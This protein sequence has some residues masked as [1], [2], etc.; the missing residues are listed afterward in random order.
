MR[1]FLYYAVHSFINQIKKLFKTWVIAFILICALM[2][3]IIGFSAA[4]ISEKAESTREEITLE[5]EEPFEAEIEISGDGIL[6]QMSVSKFQL[7]EMIAGA[8][9]LLILFLEAIGADKNGS[10]IFLPADVTLLFSA[11]LKPQSVLLFRLMSQLGTMLL[12]SIYLIFQLPNLILN[13]HLSALGACGI[14]LTWFLAL[15]AAEIIRVFL[16]ISA[17]I[18][19]IVKEHLRHVLYGLLLIIVLG[20]GLWV[21]FSG[22]GILEGIAKA[23]T[24]P[25]TNWVPFWGWLKGFMMAGI[26]G[27]IGLMLV[28]L[29]LLVV[30]VGVLIYITWRLKADFYE[31]AMEKA[32]EKAALLRKAQ[33]DKGSGIVVSGKKKKDRSEKLLRDGNMRG[34]GASVFF[35]KAMYNRFRFAHLHIFT[36]TTETY[37]AV[38]IGG[39][40]LFKLLIEADGLIPILCAFAVVAFFRAL[41]NPLSEDTKMDFFVMIPE[42]TWAKLLYS[43]LGGCAN[44]FLDMLPGAILVMIFFPANIWIGCLFLIFAVTIDIYCTCVGTFIDLAIPVNAGKIVKQLIQVMFIYFGLLPD[45][46]IIAITFVVGHL[47]MGLFMAMIVN[48]FLGG[49]FF[50]FTPFLLDSGNR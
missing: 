2:G 47:T 8:V 24:A 44:C 38:A 7:I 16:Y 5:E 20:N 23:L 1:L 33:D 35:F 34:N 29:V 21:K 48:L 46:L 11:P 4:A 14:L 50:A 41:G 12:A 30:A 49:M 6:E 15:A 43:L 28:F 26:N 22:L 37:L 27:N 42:N 31:D 45:I 36:K 32:E 9:I 25:W 19:P 39:I 18:Y 10:N 40:L 17:S 13:L 3:G